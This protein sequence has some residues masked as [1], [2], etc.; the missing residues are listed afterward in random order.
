M[1]SLTAGQ[2]II[3]GLGRCPPWEK[4]WVVG[5]ETDA[6]KECFDFLDSR[7]F[8]KTGRLPLVASRQW[9]PSW[10]AE[11]FRRF[12]KGL[13]NLQEVAWPSFYLGAV[14]SRE[15]ELFRAV[16]LPRYAATVLVC[17]ML[18]Q[19]RGGR[20][21]VVRVRVLDLDDVTRRLTLARARV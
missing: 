13:P 21:K 10:E 7:D 8:H 15:R 14:S 17:C 5:F 6:L 3:P 19:D 9:K 20:R 12:R 18:L 4:A 1:G 11:A 2:G 16:T